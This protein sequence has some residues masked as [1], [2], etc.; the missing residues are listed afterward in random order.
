M[1]E[2]KI[3]DLDK[4][5]K[6]VQEISTIS[7]EV[8]RLSTE[9]KLAQT[10]IIRTVTTDPAYFVRGKPPAM[11]F[12]EGTYSYTGINGELIEKRKSLAEMEAMLDAKKTLLDFYKTVIEVWRTQSAN[13][14]N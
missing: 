9:L 3:P 6:L 13:E 2:I 14:R 5:D 7:I 12:I 8:A 1:S 4:M 10:D 11:N